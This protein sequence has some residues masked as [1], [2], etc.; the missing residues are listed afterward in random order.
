MCSI[1]LSVLYF[2]APNFIL[3]LIFKKK[4]SK[5]MS[6]EEKENYKLSEF[7]QKLPKSSA[8]IL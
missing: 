4:D 5:K 6:L 1:L 8:T 3:Q 7:P 2:N